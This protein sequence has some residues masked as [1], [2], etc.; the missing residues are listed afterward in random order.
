MQAAF[1][2]DENW[3]VQL[4]PAHVCAESILFL[5]KKKSLDGIRIHAIALTT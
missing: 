5:H 1:V 4:E 3:D 2:A